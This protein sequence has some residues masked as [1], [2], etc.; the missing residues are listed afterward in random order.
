MVMVGIPGIVGDAY[1]GGRRRETPEHGA[2]NQHLGSAQRCIQPGINA[3]RRRG[4]RQS[5]SGG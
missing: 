3:R 2:A 4:D 1:H 5:I